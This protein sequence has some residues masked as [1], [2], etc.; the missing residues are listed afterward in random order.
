MKAAERPG[1]NASTVLQRLKALTTSP[2]N[3]QKCRRCDEGASRDCGSLVHDEWAGDYDCENADMIEQGVDCDDC[4]LTLCERCASREEIMNKQEV[5]MQIVK[6]EITGPA[7]SGKTTM[8]AIIAN[9]LEECGFRVTS[10]EQAV[11]GAVRKDVEK[12]RRRKGSLT[13]RS[14]VSIVSGCSKERR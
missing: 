12:L 2:A 3:V 1:R 7:G 13:L 9:A 6:I 14:I 8:A 4:P 5:E 10:D 11:L